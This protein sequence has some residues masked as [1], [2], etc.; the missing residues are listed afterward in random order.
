MNKLWMM[1]VAGCVLVVAGCVAKKEERGP[2][3]A[4]DKSATTE[5]PAP[6]NENEGNPVEQLRA[7]IAELEARAEK[8]ADEIQVQHLLVAFAGSGVPGVTRTREEAEQ[9][10]AELWQ[11]IK[12]GADFDALIREHTNDSPPGIY[13]MTMTGPG[14]RNQMMFPRKG[15]VPAFGNVGWRLEVDEYGVAPHDPATSPYGWHIVKR[16][17]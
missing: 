3:P 10:T 15:M 14:D 1:W 13:A 2:A 9:L 5:Q 8:Q 17:R 16:L 7:D 4:P 11:Q 12:D 6:T